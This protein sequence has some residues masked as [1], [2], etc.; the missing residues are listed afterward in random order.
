[1]PAGKPLTTVWEGTDAD[2]MPILVPFWA[3][4]DPAGGLEILDITYGTGKM[5]AKWPDEWLSPATNDLYVAGPDRWGRYLS[6]FDYG[7]LPPPNELDYFDVIVFDPPHFG[8]KGT[9]HA[10]GRWTEKYGDGGR[11]VTAGWREF[12]VSAATLVKPDGIVIAKIADQVH[13]GKQQMQTVQFMNWA[14]EV[15]WRVCD[16]IIKVRKAPGPSNWK[17]QLH[18]RRRHSHF[19]CLRRG[20]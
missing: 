14:T 8:D 10:S 6:R 18:A 5:W 4:K 9:P 1:M 12:L 15:G 13:S 3:R 19:I 11:D 7:A 16:V 2:L 17:T 20:C